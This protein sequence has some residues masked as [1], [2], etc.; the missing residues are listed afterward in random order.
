MTDIRANLGAQ[1]QA[2]EQKRHRHRWITFDYHG[3]RCTSCSCGA[4]KDEARSRQG[5]TA[6]DRGNRRELYIERK[7]GPKKVGQ[8]GAAVDNIGRDFKWQSKTTQAEPPMWVTRFA[9]RGITSLLPRRW[10]TVPMVHM[11]GVRDDLY[12]LVIKSWTRQGRPSIDVIV[13]PVAAWWHL[14]GDPGIE[15]GNWFL[16]MTGDHFLEVHGRDEP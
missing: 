6:R 13:V 1:R 16:A 3:H 8:F 15:R 9:D 14:H 12:P 5:R 4:V 7:Y 11:D 10:F 2:G